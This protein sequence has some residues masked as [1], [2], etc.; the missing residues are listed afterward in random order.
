MPT[1]LSRKQIVD[2]IK[3]FGTA[4]D[5]HGQNLQGLD[6][7]GLDLTNANLQGANLAGADMGP[8]FPKFGT[9][10]NGA[11]LEGANLHGVNSLPR[12][13]VWA[14]AANADFSNAR[15]YGDDW[16]GSNFRGANLT[17][18]EIINN[19]NW[20]GAD[21]SGANLEGLKAP[22]GVLNLRSSKLVGANL[23]GIRIGH[24]GDFTYADLTEAD[25]RYADLRKCHLNGAI[26]A[27]AKY[28][29]STLWPS[30]SFVPSMVG[31]VLTE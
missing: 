21:L 10:L 7:S 13:L 11:N 30:P 19:L 12:K 6:L 25:L 15:A 28:N 27:R 29:H 3:S 8:K 26:L 22:N 4:L 20:S 31:A 2:M 1:L 17:N 16:S 9:I 23:K 18:L 24:Y 14:I 5:L